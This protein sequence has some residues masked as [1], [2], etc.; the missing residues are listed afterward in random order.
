MI[1]S[2]TSSTNIYRSSNDTILTV[3][4]SVGFSNSEFVYQG[5]TLAGSTAR[6]VLRYQT[7]NKLYVEEASAPFA[8]GVNVTGATSTNIGA[9]TNVDPSA[10]GVLCTMPWT[11][12]IFSEKE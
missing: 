3:N 2:N 6:G 1:T 7:N 11:H 8:N 12:T 5:G 9:V 10:N 4:A